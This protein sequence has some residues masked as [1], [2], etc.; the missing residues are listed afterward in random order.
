MDIA[1]LSMAMASSSAMQQASMAAVKNA[2][3][4]SQVQM[5]GVVD[6]MRS[7]S[8]APSFG[9]VFDVRV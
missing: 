2:M 4:V 6:M 1:A 8:S 3:E 5:Q 9:H 7:A